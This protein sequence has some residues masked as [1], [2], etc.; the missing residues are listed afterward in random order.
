MV[1]RMS[2][3]SEDMLAERMGRLREHFPEVR[4]SRESTARVLE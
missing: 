3:G 2:L 1:E 4:H